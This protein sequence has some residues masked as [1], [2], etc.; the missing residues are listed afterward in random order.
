MII[1]LGIAN[2]CVAIYENGARVAIPNEPGYRSTPSCVG[3]I[4]NKYKIEK[5]AEESSGKKWLSML[6]MRSI[7]TLDAFGYAAALDF[8]HKNPHNNWHKNRP[9]HPKYTEFGK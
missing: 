6:D 7:S 4:K 2:L 1:D 3:L 5:S 8:E 9:N